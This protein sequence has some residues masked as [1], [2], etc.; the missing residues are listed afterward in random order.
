MTVM[1]VFW[2]QV[3]EPFRGSPP[4]N[5]ITDNC[6]TEC[7]FG[8]YLAHGKSQGTADGSGCMTDG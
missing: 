3:V 1:L 8:E 6:Y 7:R 2:T 4:V 5:A